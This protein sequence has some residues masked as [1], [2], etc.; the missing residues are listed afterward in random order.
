[1]QDRITIMAGVLVGIIFFIIGFYDC[2]DFKEEREKYEG[3]TEIVCDL[4]IISCTETYHEEM[5]EPRE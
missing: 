1:M 5:L 4:E 3:W 2:T